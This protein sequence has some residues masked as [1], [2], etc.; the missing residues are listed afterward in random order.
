MKS[1]EKEFILTEL[2]ALFQV[3]GDIYEGCSFKN[4]LDE[5][6]N[7]SIEEMEFPF[8]T[9][10][11]GQRELAVT[12]YN[13]IRNNGVLFAQAPTGIGKTISTIFP[14][15]KGLANNMGER[16]VYLTSKTITRVVAEEAYAMLIKNGL[17]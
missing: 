12:C 9:Y 10:R 5:E 11:K 13:T 14:A 2:E 7:K 1:F 3:S 17:R 4:S 16:I 8:P 6:R 15:I